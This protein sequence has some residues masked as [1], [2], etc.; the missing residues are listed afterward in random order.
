VRSVVLPFR[1]AAATLVT[2]VTSTLSDLGARDEL[3]LVDDGSTDGSAAL[4][5]TFA[6]K[7]ARI[8]A[9]GT[10]GAGLAAALR[11]G[12]ASARGELVARM[13]ADDVLLPGR[14]RAQAAAMEADATLAAVGCRVRVEG[15][16]VP[17]G[18]GL[19]R[20]VEWQ[21]GLLSPEEHA[22][23]RFVES[24][25]CHPATMLRR[26]AVLAVGGYRDV[27]WP[28]DWDL[29]LRLVAAGHRI[30]K[31]AHEGLVWRHR[32]GRETFAAPSCSEE[33]LRRAR[34][35]HLAP[36]LRERAQPVGVW[37]AG[38][39]G[40]RLARALEAEGVRTERFFDIDPRKIGRTARGAP[41][42]PTSAVVRGEGTL[43]VAVGARG[44]R[45]VV[46]AQL[47]ARGFVEL[48]DYVC[49]A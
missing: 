31:V 41:I 10:G 14:I 42:A 16:D 47:A 49:A 38:G 44:A 5:A 39:T 6:R 36:W 24:P 1:N 48:R 9:L 35:H 37:G 29:W 30:G 27:P 20:Y 32:A 46:R 12:L 22:R 34:A 2:A 40:R 19:L 17:V 8:R 26:S 18:A 28:E 7:D 3:V 4:A 21:N 43:V 11:A 25:L 33:A 23:D 13:D 45:V 15:L